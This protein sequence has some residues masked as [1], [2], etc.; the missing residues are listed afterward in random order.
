MSIYFRKKAVFLSFVLVM[1][2]AKVCLPKD[3][4]DL[5]RENSRLKQRV[6]RLEKELE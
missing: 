6:E 3:I 1:A 5:D 4:N 2:S